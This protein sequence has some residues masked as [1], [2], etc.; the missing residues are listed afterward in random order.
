MRKSSLALGLV[1]LVLTLFIFANMRALIATLER[2]ETAAIVSQSELQAEL[3]VMKILK[4]AAKGEAAKFFDGIEPLPAPE[5]G[6]EL[7][8]V[9]KG[10]RLEIRRP[11][12]E[13]AGLLFLKTIASRQLDALRGL[14]KVLSGLVAFL[15]LL[16]AV[17]GIYF[18]V[19]LFRKPPA[20]GKPSAGSPFQD[21]LLEMKNAQT[22]LQAIVAEQRRASSERE[23]LNQSIINTVH[24]GVICLSA[25]GKVEIFNPAAQKLFRRSFAAAKNAL[26]ADVLPGNPELA[27]FILTAEA[28]GSAEIESG[29][30]IFFVDVVTLGDG[31]LLAL[32]RDVSEERQRERLRRQNDDLMMLG[33]MAASLAHEVRN[34]LGVILGYSKA[35][36]GDVEKTRK[37]VREI[38]FLSE[39]MESFLRFARPPDPVNRGPV[40]L[41]PLVAAAA[42][43]QGM[44]VDLP[45]VPLELRSDPLL[46]NIV[47]GN[48]ALNARQSGATRLRLDFAAND[49]PVVMVRDDGPGIAAA[50]AEKIWLPFFTTRDKGTGMGLAT[51]KK[52]VSALGADIQLMNPGEPGAQFKIVFYS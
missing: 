41:G 19:L 13:S 39:M 46:L 51:V 44:A 18:M 42:A 25:A 29:G 45:A 40:D 24:L 10:L 34:S 2:N 7:V 47:F 21:Y 5:T 12:G 1:V 23:E 8:R 9:G 32:V 27:R 48:L 52:L 30:A 11:L 28:K 31:R 33:E 14:K 17:G 35:Q 4:G 36:G 43:A 3:H 50:L 22:E 6:K 26:L 37:V 20:E 49:P 16:L 38:E 15:G